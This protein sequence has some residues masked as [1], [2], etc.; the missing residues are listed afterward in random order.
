MRQTQ[1]RGHS[2]PVK[3]GAVVRWVAG[4][5]SVPGT[6]TG[7]LHS[8]AGSAVSPSASVQSNEGAGQGAAAAVCVAGVEGRWLAWFGWWAS[9]PA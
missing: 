6:A 5:A 7:G 8:L 1:V 4:T 9:W 2:A 3:A